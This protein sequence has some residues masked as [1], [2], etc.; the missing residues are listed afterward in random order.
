[1][2]SQGSDAAVSLPFGRLGR[3]DD[4]VMGRGSACPTGSGALHRRYRSET[5]RY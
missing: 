1:V 3:I 4:P 5:K 2:L